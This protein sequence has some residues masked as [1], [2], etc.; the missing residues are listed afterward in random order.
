MSNRNRIRYAEEIYLHDLCHL[1]HKSKDMKK[2]NAHQH[3]NKENL[4]CRVRHTIKNYSHFKIE[5][6]LAY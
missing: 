3:M 2:I 6:N 1:V 4:V 5:L